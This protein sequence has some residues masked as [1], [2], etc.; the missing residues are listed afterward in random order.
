MISLELLNSTTVAPR[1]I[2]ALCP[3][4]TFRVTSLPV[5]A[6]TFLAFLAHMLYTA[7]HSTR[8]TAQ[9]CTLSAEQLSAGRQLILNSDCANVL[10]F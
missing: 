7:S 4:Q 2:A 5:A 3:V 9:V 1:T 10:L 8:P 6:V